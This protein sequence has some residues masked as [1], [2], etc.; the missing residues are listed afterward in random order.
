M[1]SSSESV[2]LINKI[3]ILY[4]I[5]FFVFKILLLIQQGKFIRGA[6]F[7]ESFK[8]KNIK[9]NEKIQNKKKSGTHCT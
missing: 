6:K 4:P 1:Y 2:D 9:K 7:P 5:F 8:L 3:Y